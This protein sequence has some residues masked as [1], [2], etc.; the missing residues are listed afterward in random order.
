V[1][2]RKLIAISLAALVAWCP[3]HCLTS[4]CRHQETV[5]EPAAVA[6]DCD[7]C[8]Y[9]SGDPPPADSGRSG[10]RDVPSPPQ[11]CNCICLCQGAISTDQLANVLDFDGSELESVLEFVVGKHALSNPLSSWDASLVGPV[12]RTGASARAFLSCWIL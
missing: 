1:I 10:E 7:C 8:A 4:T 6:T 2:F 5:T 11:K 3:L 9:P 12:P